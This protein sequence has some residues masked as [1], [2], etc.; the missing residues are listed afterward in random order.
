[1][2]AAL[3]A[4]AQSPAPTDVIWPNTTKYLPAVTI[5]GIVQQKVLV[6][7]TLVTLRMHHTDQWFKNGR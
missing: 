3:I 7:S 6:V 4:L 5:R 2:N 1:M